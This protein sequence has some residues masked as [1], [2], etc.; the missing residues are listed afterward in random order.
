MRRGW[1]SGKRAES[2]RCVL[3]VGSL[4]PNATFRT[5]ISTPESGSSLVS[6][7]LQID[8]DTLRT[9]DKRRQRMEFQQAPRILGLLRC[10]SKL[11]LQHLDLSLV[12]GCISPR[13]DEAHA[14][15]AGLRQTNKREAERWP[16]VTRDGVASLVLNFY[17]NRHWFEGSTE[18]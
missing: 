16:V 15:N 8:M 1:R 14:D 13:D 4:R 3:E 10:N 12:E 2:F 11:I 7:E 5:P 6:D 17:F 9:F 18:L